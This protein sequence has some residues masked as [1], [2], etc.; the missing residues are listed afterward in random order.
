MNK[1]HRFI[2]SYIREQSKD[3]PLFAGFAAL[4]DEK[5]ARQMFSNYRTGKGL[6]LTWF[7][8]EVM[9]RHFKSYKIMVPKNEK[10]QP[11]HLIFLDSHATMPYFFGDEEIVVFDH[12]LGIKLRLIDGRLSTLVEIGD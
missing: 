8:W 2:V 1:V 12:E 10:M 3:D 4:T 5:M 9:A 7:G 11:S 6:R